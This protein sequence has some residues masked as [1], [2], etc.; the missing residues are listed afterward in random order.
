MVIL[1]GYCLIFLEEG[2]PV[3][4]VD[5][6]KKEN[7]GNF[8]NNGK[9][10]RRK[11]HPRKGLDHDFPIEELGKMAHYGIYNVNKNMGFVNIGT[12]RD[13]S[14]FAVE[15]LS[16]WRES[17][18]KRTFSH[19]QKL[20][21]TCDCGG[22]HGNRARMWKYQLQQFADRTRLE[23]QVSHF[24]PGTSKWNKIE[25]RLFCYISKSCQG[26]PLVDV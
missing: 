6:K 14:E 10:Y 24:P 5:T 16:R 19:M 13:T 20:Y 23:I 7:I 25:H 1:C 12:S 18:G 17:V 21:I 3:I 11:G 26:K 2:E 22:S 4:F 9:E 15:S 8:K